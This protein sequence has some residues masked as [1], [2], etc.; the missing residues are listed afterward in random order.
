MQNL[1]FKNSFSPATKD[2]FLVLIASF[3]VFGVVYACN[4]F[5][6]FYHDDF[7][8]ASLSYVYDVGGEFKD[9]LSLR[10]LIKFLFYHYMRW[11]GR[12]NAFAF[13]VPL[14]HYGPSVFFFVQTV[15]TTLIVI[16]QAKIICLLTK[17]TSYIFILSVV[18]ILC[19]YMLIPLNV[20]YEGIYWATASALYLWPMVF[21][22]LGIYFIC[23]KRFN[24]L[25]IFLFFLVASSN[26]VYSIIASSYLLLLIIIHKNKI[27]Y[28]RYYFI[29]SLCGSL[30]LWLS[31][32]NIR[33]M[34]I[35]KVDTSDFISHFLAG[36]SRLVE[37]LQA[38]EYS[39]FFII[40]LLLSTLF[41]FYKITIS[42]NKKFLVY[43]PFIFPFFTIPFFYAFSVSRGAR[44]LV[45][46]Y[47]LIP[48]I[49]APFYIYIFN[50]Y[51]FSV[52]ILGFIIWIS[53]SNYSNV[54]NGYYK[55]YG[56]AI[57]NERI[58]KNSKNAKEILLKK[59][60]SRRHRATMPYDGDNRAYINKWI[61][62]YYN[63]KKDI[64]LIYQ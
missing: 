1:T 3:G 22:T 9:R 14:M 40:S 30:F 55:N 4:F 13:A 62:T 43:L 27:K 11:G 12:T 8:Y 16:F 49:I 61:L 50:K 34:A 63:L 25:T 32:G 42:K 58:L 59:F 29:S 45:P 26:E 21:L 6:H 15:V 10:N 19:C 38:W 64:K 33:R 37:Y 51:K 44:V 47:L 39:S 2:F 20:S 46:Y 41:I 56:I 36:I 31:P 35:Q 52:L 60:P 5:I 57:E 7:A 48:F 53:V 54:I 23:I 28:Y 18:L 17:K 24:I